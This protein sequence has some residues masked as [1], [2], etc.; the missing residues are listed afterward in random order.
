MSAQVVAM[1][2]AIAT[3]A[4]RA[5]ELGPIPALVYLSLGR[6]PYVSREELRRILQRGA[7]PT[8]GPLYL[9]RGDRMVPLA[10]LVDDVTA[11]LI[12]SGLLHPAGLPCP[13]C[14]LAGAVRTRGF[15]VHERVARRRRK[16]ETKA[17]SSGVAGTAGS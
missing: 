15:I 16:W 12:S 2:W 5:F 4:E 8:V 11:A 10:E 7:G 17:G 9:R 6:R 14:W 1:P 3:P 13:A